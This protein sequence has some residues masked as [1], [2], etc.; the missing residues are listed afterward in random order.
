M[1]QLTTETKTRQVLPSQLVHDLRTPLNQIIG[2][3]E[4]LAEQ[5]QESGQAGLLPDLER[6]RGAGKRMLKII[7]ENFDVDSGPALAAKSPKFAE[8][9]V[10]PVVSEA[11]SS[12]TGGSLLV[13]DDEEGNRDVL[14][15]LL[16]K[17]GYFV[18]MA[19]NGQKAL[20]ML[21]ADAYDMVLLDIMMPEL[22]GYEVLRRIR[23]DSRLQHI[24]VVMISALSDMDSVARCITLG[25]EDYLP[26]P[27]NSTLLK[28]RIGACLEKKRGHDREVR[29]YEQL[30]EN[31]AKLHQLEEL[32][33]DLTNMIIHD[34]RT[35]L[36]SVLAA[37]QTLDVVGELNQAQRE[38]MQIAVTGADTLLAAINS[39]LD[40]EKLESGAMELD[41]S[42][43]SLPELTS[44][45]VAQVATLAA[46]KNLTLVQ[47]VPPDLP[48]LQGDEG[49]LQ[50]VLVNLLGNAIKFTPEGGTVTLVVRHLVEAKMVEFSVHDTGE[51]IPSDSFERI[52]EK[53]GQLEPR[54]GSQLMGTGLGLTFCKLAVEAH[55]GTISVE[56]EPGNGSTFRFTIPLKPA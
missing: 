12:E 42:L 31:Y 43:L 34:L 52:F 49:K 11:G 23:A 3:S 1:T 19:E 38:V 25:A 18:A 5:A 22:D 39:L 21:G 47:D 14:S 2:Y 50:R 32:R 53:F 30:Q 44:A 35:P 28:A 29:L 27:F 37:M 9:P 7:D 51:G 16:A 33:D 55:G 10:D 6:V 36:S 48:W 24:P 13:V 8:F 4:M 17:Q 15:R 56:S 54:E 45:A 46:A 41:S 40:V 20:D 26:K